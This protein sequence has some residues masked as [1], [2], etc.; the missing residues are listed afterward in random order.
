MPPALV[1]EATLI[2][3]LF[4]RVGSMIMLMPMLG[5]ESVPRQIR[6]LLALGLT[7]ALSGILK[8]AVSPLLG[9]GEVRLA[10]LLL[11]ET[12]TGLA[13][14]M[15]ARL[16]FQAAV[17]AGSIVSMQIGL[18]TALVFDPA[19][20]GQTPL[21]GKLIGLGSTLFCFT[22]GLHG[23]W[24]EALIRSYTCFAPGAPIPAAD[25]ASLAVSTAAQA[26]ALAI[27]LAAP[28][29]MFGILFNLA[30]GIAG[31]LAPSIQFFF[32]A[33]PLMIA[34]GIALLAVTAPAMMAG[35]ADAYR[36]WMAGAW[37]G[38]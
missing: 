34:G 31:R 36:E 33:Q 7:I 32:I 26:T 37:A 23:W 29:L 8:P 24:F 22:L 12:I 3:L 1:A 38:V 6:L 18:T 17:M 9:I 35:F 11:T 20:G 27:S 13:L 25:W 4:A 10:G 15:L 30:L 19:T 16:F 14:G 28:F 21:L 2:L 5:D